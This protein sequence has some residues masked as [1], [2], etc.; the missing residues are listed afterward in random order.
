VAEVLARIAHGG[1]RDRRAPGG[2]PPGPRAGL[3]KGVQVSPSNPPSQAPPR[4]ARL[5]ACPRSK[6]VGDETPTF[7]GSKGPVVTVVVDGV[8][9]SDNELGNAVFCANT[10]A[11][12]RLTKGY[13]AGRWAPP[14]IT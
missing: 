6:F 13:C 1:A 9:Y 3:S 14:P 12:N 7:P 8:G 5:S 4:S 11:W 10:P 2:A